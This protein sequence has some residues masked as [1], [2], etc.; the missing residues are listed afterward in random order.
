MGIFVDSVTRTV[1]G[2]THIYN[3][4]LQFEGGTTNVMLGRT[5]A[6]KTTLLR[7]MAG[8][9]RP[10][11]GRIVM[12]GKDVT[13]VSVR[14][15]SVAM[16][17]QQFVNYPSLT[18]YNN[19]ASPLKM[20]GV[21]KRETDRKVREAAA[22]L[23]IEDLLD[24]LPAQ[25]SGGQQ[26]RTAIARALVKEAELL[27][28][29]EPLVNLDY[30]LR[31]ELR[32]ELQDI[33]KQRDTIVVYTTTEPAEALML[34]GN[35]VVMDEGRVLQT[36]TTPEV[37]RNPVNVRVA[38]IFSD[39]PINYLEGTVEGDTIKLGHN[40][41][42]PLEGHM[43]NLAAGHYTFGVRSNHLFLSRSDDDDAEI[44]ATVELAEIN[45]SE[46]F[47]HVI[48]ANRQLVVQEDG[49]HPH[50]MGSEIS[51]YVSPCCFFVYDENGQLVASP[52]QFTIQKRLN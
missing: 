46:T 9:D 21:S 27:L 36:G 23:H 26:Q 18:V 45:G 25:L 22:M 24:R 20:G 37:Y 48:H 41:E 1:G 34:G 12:D 44:R 32:V 7:L 47:I 33:F 4:D 13:G 2:E 30:K 35:V 3:A 50:R 16:V 17:Y 28:L 49:I 14:K 31:E 39:P 42:I 40:I 5:L 51:V 19:I 8:L 29:D 43:S 52:S 10:T 11:S 38:E 6:G 15:R